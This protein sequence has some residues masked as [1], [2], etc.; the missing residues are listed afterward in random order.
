MVARLGKT[1]GGYTISLTAGMVEELQLTEGSAVEV[2][3]APA[4]VE[5][6][7]PPIRYASAEEVIAAFERTLPNHENTYRELVK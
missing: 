5:E 7:R 3:R 2:L 6:S 1:Q 4:V